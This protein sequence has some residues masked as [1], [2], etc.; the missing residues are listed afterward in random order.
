M[1]RDVTKFLYN[2]ILKLSTSGVDTLTNVLFE[3]FSFE[4][5]VNIRRH[6]SKIR[7]SSADAAGLVL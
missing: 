4:D 5:L 6:S 3:T 1:E 2:Q 7:K